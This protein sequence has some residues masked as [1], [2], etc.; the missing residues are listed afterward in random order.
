MSKAADLD[1]LKVNARLYKQ[2]ARLLDDLEDGDNRNEITIPQRINALIAIGRIQ[3]MFAGLRKAARDESDQPT[4]GAVR[5][6]ATAFK[7]NAPRGRTGAARSAAQPAFDPDDDPFG[8][9][10]G[11]GA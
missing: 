6:F 8:T 4:G 1:P 10:D 7:T 2:I 9:T 11:E 3:G 5:K